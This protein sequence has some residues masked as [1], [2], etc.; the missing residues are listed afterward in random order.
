VWGR[1]TA[2]CKGGIAVLIA[3]LQQLHRAGLEPVRPVTALFLADEESGE[4]GSGTSEGIRRAIAAAA[5]GRMPISAD[6]AIYGEPTTMQVYT[7]HMGFFITDVVLTGKSAYFGTPELGVDALRAADEVLRALWAHDE[8]LRARHADPLI[9]APSLLVTG[10]TGGGSVAVPGECRISI[11]RKLTPIEDLAEARDEL[12]SVIRTAVSDKRI[13]VSTSYPAGRDHELGGT[14]L[15]TDPELEPVRRLQ[16]IVKRH[17][18]ER[19]EIAAGP[20]W[21]EGPFLRRDLGIP[22]VY[23]APGDISHCHTFDEHV[24]VDEYIAAVA[25][26]L[27]FIVEH[28]GVRDLDQAAG[29]ASSSTERTR[30]AQGV[31]P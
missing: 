29:V 12:E 9:G 17:L 20:Y 8:D 1:G 25:V 6:L 11:I 31:T 2:D 26:Y 28:C 14:A 19:G 15:V 27:E 3:A 5:A 24:K 23:L 10:V 4:E 30:D 22:T 18:P 21:S 16:E 13:T 7:S